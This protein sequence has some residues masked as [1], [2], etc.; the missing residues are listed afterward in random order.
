MMIGLSEKDI[1][2]DVHVNNG[3]RII[4]VYCNSH[5]Y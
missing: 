1:K 5:P 4:I 3:M 2:N